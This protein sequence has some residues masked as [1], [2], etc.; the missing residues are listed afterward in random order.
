[1]TLTS[2]KP[3]KKIRKSKYDSHPVAW[4]GGF[5]IWNPELKLDRFES[6]DSWMALFRGRR[7]KTRYLT[8]YQTLEDRKD[9]FWQRFVYGRRNKRGSSVSCRENLLYF[10]MTNDP[11]N[12][13]LTPCQWDTR[14]HGPI[15]NPNT[16][17]VMAPHRT[18]VGSLFPA[19][20][21]G[22]LS[23]RWH[24]RVTESLSRVLTSKLIP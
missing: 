20:C 17:A 3:L 16:H 18:L 9:S 19:P 15:T 11:V 22:A 13:E 1:M 2:R 4:I 10:V 24:Y 12:V 5:K 8:P 6:F 14:F 23:D 7:W 21:H